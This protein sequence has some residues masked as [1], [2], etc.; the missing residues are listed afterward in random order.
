MATC[1][2]CGMPSVG[3]SKYCNTHRAEAR[4][5]WVERVKADAAAR[6]QRAEGFQELWDK[7]SAAGNAAAE[8]TVPVPMVVAQRANM[9]DDSSPV[10][11]TWDVPSGVCGF[12]W[13]TVRPGNSAFANWLKKKGYGKPDSYAGGVTVWCPL[14]TQSMEIKSAWAHAVAEVLRGAGVKAYG[15]DRMD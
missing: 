3:N 9:L 6:E 14:S 13:V 4:K 1:P 7:A 2:N 10:V 11:K 5:A 12:A 15:R 8:K